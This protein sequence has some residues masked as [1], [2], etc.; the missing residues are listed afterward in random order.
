MLKNAMIPVVTVVGARIPAIIGGSVIL[1]QVMS[2]QGMGQYL[3]QAVLAKDYP[4]VQ[5]MCMYIGALMIISNLAVDV[6]Y[7]Y[8]DPRIRYR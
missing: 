7:A 1:E 4:I 8:F 2:I 5:A 3:Y 6:S